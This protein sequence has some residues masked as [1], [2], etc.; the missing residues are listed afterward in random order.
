VEWQDLTTPARILV[1][2]PVTFA[3]TDMAKRGILETEFDATLPGAGWKFDWD[4][5]AT[6]VTITVAHYPDNVRWE[7]RTSEHWGTFYIGDKLDDGTPVQ[8]N[9]QS[10]SPHVLVA[11]ETGSGKLDELSTKILT[12][13]GWRRFGDIHPGDEVFA[14]DGTPVKVVF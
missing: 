12:P 4:T 8:F 2:F 6:T 7:G 3:K 5:T 11:G 14:P 10:E 9:V 13:K 1:S